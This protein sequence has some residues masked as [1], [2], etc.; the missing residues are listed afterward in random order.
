MLEASSF[1]DHQS[2]SSPLLGK[3]F[4]K[5]PGQGQRR[6]SESRN[7]SSSPRTLTG[8][9]PA[10]AEARLLCHRLV[11]CHCWSEAPPLELDW[12][13]QPASC[14]RACEEVSCQPRGRSCHQFCCS[15]ALPL[16]CHHGSG[17]EDHR[18]LRVLVLLGDLLAMALAK[19]VRKAKKSSEL[20]S[21]AA[22]ITE[23]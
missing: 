15:Q 5:G 17:S 8:G 14:Q 6:T 2:P 1:V 13:C 20:E 11:S 21:A 12:S 18:Q 3:L 10:S 4:V 23:S 22:K 9:G 16:F 19:K 7:R